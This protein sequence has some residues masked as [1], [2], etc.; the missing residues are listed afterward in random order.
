MNLLKEQFI[1]SV[2][3]KELIFK[4]L[5]N[6]IFYNDYELNESN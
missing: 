1:E 4:I 5:E 3:K 2:F 6:S